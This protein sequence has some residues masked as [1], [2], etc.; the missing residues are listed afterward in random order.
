[1][2]DIFLKEI[3]DLFL[4]EATDLLQDVENLFL[5]LEKDPA[6]KKSLDTLFRLAHNLKGSGK[7]VGFNEL[8]T[9]AHQVENVLI[10][11]RE[12]QITSSAGLIN[13]FLECV[14]FL[15][16][17]IESLK[18]DN[19]FFVQVDVVKGM[20][21]KYLSNP[22]ANSESQSPISGNVNDPVVKIEQFGIPPVKR[23]PN[24]YVRNPGA[25]AGY[26][27][28]PLA[29][30]DEI[31]NLFGE[32]VIL[33]SALDQAKNDLRFNEAMVT[34]GIGQLNKLTYDLQQKVMGLRMV[35]MRSMF[36]KL[37]RAVRDTAQMLNKK[38]EFVTEGEENELDKTIIEA[39]SDPLTHMVRNSVD[40][41]IES[42]E[43]RA[44]S[45]KP[46]VGKVILR[47]LRKGGFF[48][49]ELTD[50]GK[51]LD[52]DKLLSKAKRQ[53]LVA[54]N[55]DMKEGDIY[56]LIFLNGFSSKDQATEISGRGVGM[57][58][59]REAV[60]SQKG[61]I[62]IESVVGQGTTFTIRLPLTLAVFNGMVVS[63]NEQM[64]V[65]PNSDVNEVVIF[66]EAHM[67]VVNKNEQVIQIRDEVMP[68][69]N[70]KKKLFHRSRSAKSNQPTRSSL[71]ISHIN[72][73][74]YAF[75]I[76]EVVSNQKI[77]HKK[78]GS[79]LE[80][81]KLASGATVL[82]DGSVALILELPA[83]VS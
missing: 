26:M 16:S 54:A 20:I 27:R 22:S 17:S 5:V 34:R 33:Q 56:N 41:G 69:V 12:G 30:I 68:I 64:Y 60:T 1:M 63:I 61:S 66:N 57:N 48:Q 72:Q 45:G 77:V 25:D 83:M 14:D 32:Q 7:S 62:S 38:I 11:L 40:H 65:V 21:A 81:I 23:D 47:A 35:N 51:G 78:F 75:L 24:E 53:G 71:L 46:P 31:L 52:K 37:S 80:N 59:V 79:E 82:G 42:A 29:R 8:S 74:Q 13:L 36:S 3:Q 50:D 4:V 2:D 19:H 70:L 67:R 43:E 6:D 39:L 55:A 9:A 44:R 73:K 49:F 10:S 76:D 18:A 15:K 28:V 58:V